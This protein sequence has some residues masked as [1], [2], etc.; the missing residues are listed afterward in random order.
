MRMTIKA[1]LA[2]VFGTVILMSGASMYV[3][4]QNLDKLNQSLDM[5]VNV[6]AA[7]A[8]K[9]QDMQTH[10]QSVGAA[11]NGMVAS[12]DDATIEKYAKEMAENKEHAESLFAE[13]YSNIKDDKIRAAA[14]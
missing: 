8:L 14:D 9:E 12:R 1:K 7:N 13:L 4:L 11:L 2:A 10:L 5:I 6:R 3:A